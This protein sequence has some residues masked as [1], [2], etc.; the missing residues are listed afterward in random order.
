VPASVSNF[1]ADALEIELLLKGTMTS[2]AEDLTLAD[3]HSGDSPD[4]FEKCHEFR[5]MIADLEQRGYFQRL[6]R[7]P[8][9][10][11]C[12]D[13]N[14]CCRPVQPVSYAETFSSLRVVSLWMECSRLRCDG[15]LMMH[16]NVSL[17]KRGTVQ[18]FPPSL[19]AEIISMK[20]ALRCGT[21]VMA[22][23]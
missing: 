8:P 16:Q 3:F 6:Y 7:V 23:S 15:L 17:N 1:S 2:T 22:R 10:I 5:G 21:S 20:G 18:T 19:A 13:D 9:C 4:L 14:A 11:S 12:R